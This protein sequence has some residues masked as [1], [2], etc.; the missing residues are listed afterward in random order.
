M[1]RFSR[2]EPL[3]AVARGGE[4][5]VI[6]AFDRVRG[7]PVAL[8]CRPTGHACSPEMLAHEASVVRRLMP[9][10]G[11][12]CYR[13]DFFTEAC[14]V[15]VIDWIE[16]PTLAS[17]LDRQGR[18]GLPPRSVLGWIDKIAAVLDHLHAHTPA[19][20]HGDVNP[21]NVILR[22]DGR[23]ALVDFG[24]SGAGGGHPGTAGGTRGYVAPEMA[25]G[26]PLTPAA[27]VFGLAATAVALLNGASL[28][29]RSP[30]WPGHT[31]AQASVVEA[32]LGPALCIDP[33]RRPA[34]AGALVADLVE[35]GIASPAAA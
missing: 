16:G 15:L 30:R 2:Y 4:S 14:H 12:P 35:A 31:S 7:V 24:L 20:V 10:P 6:R 5:E 18:P 17:V 32:T 33:T 27:D 23:L 19:V 13:E 21:A 34:S 29:Q 3:G 1:L 25:V 9:H 28:A 11:L 22:P 26:G 8:K